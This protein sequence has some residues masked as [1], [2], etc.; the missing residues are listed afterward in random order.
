MEGGVENNVEF[1]VFVI[2]CRAFAKRA[3]AKREQRLVIETLPAYMMD[4][5]PGLW[6]LKAIPLEGSFDV[7]EMWY[8]ERKFWCC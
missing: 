1:W 5:L 8:V 7:E 2:E 3:F 4:L 6:S